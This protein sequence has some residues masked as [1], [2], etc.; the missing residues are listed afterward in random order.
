MTAQQREHSH[1][2]ALPAVTG[3]PAR[4]RPAWLIPVL[5]VA[6][7]AAVALAL[8]GLVSPTLLIYAGVLAGCGLMHL[9]GHGGHG[10]HR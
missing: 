10:G 7:A 1:Q 6:G 3:M 5:G 2:H 4:R 9:F 8:S